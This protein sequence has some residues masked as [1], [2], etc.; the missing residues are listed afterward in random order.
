[1]KEAVHTKSSFKSQDLEQ[2]KKAVTAKIEKLINRQ[3]KK[4]S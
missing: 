4:A 2:I 1:M 3:I